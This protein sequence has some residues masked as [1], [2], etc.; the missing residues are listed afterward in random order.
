MASL[1]QRDRSPFWWIKYRN[2]GG[3]T[4]YESTGYRVG[5]GSETAKARQLKAR[6]T[7]EEA[8]TARVSSAEFFDHWVLGFLDTRYGKRF[9]TFTKYRQCWNAISAYLESL[10]IRRPR[11]VKREHVMGYLTWRQKP[12]KDSGLRAVC[13]NSAL[14]DIRIWRVIMFEAVAREYAMLNPCSKL[15]ISADDPEEKEEISPEDETTIRELLRTEPEWMRISFEIAMHQ[16]CRFS[17]T[18]VP[19][20]DVNLE[21]NQITFTIKGGHRHTT[22][23][24]PALR[25]MM[26]RFNSEGRETTF[27][28]PT[29]RARH[30]HRF[31]HKNGM[32]HLS[33]HCTRV[34]VIT[35][36][37][38]AGVAEQQAMRF[39]GHATLEVHRVYQKLKTDDLAA[40]IEV[41]NHPCAA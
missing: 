13:L 39:I 2:G 38:R 21:R 20:K 17:E 12:P 8:D 14:L 41:L 30:W 18:C 5:V 9:N 4:C 23:L 32:G 36:L 6:K 27:E 40:C 10:N 1:Y 34:T 29:Q 26:E 33:F 15:G 7:Q 3:K 11:Q 37:A 16:G 35:R 22:S 24:V 28:M 25:P 31:F 19:M